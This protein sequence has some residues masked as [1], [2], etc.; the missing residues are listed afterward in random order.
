MQTC[1]PRRWVRRAGASGCAHTRGATSGTEEGQR[2]LGYARVQ[3]MPALVDPPPPPPEACIQLVVRQRP[4]VKPAAPVA[5][6]SA[7]RF[8][9]TAP[10]SHENL[11]CGS[12]HGRRP[13][14]RPPCR[15]RRA[16][17]TGSRVRSRRTVSPAGCRARVISLLEP[18]T[19]E[20]LQKAEEVLA[21]AACT[22]W[23]R[24]RTRFPTRT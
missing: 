15:R 24:W 16:G 12:G 20:S 5:L 10:R 11:A 18:S 4:L 7:L 19:R 21:M 1:A 23:S 2:Q 6:P 13:R 22:S 3:A 14:A 8:I 17:A 9:G